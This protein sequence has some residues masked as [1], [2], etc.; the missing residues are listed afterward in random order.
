MDW[1]KLHSTHGTHLWQ[2]VFRYI[3]DILFSIYTGTHFWQGV[4]R[5][6][7]DI[8]FSIH[9]HGTQL[10]QKIFKYMDD[11]QLIEFRVWPTLNS[12]RWY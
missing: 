12:V 8:L 10:W 3:D 11:I 7:D 1:P 5:Y 6:M 4:F 9:T 2:G